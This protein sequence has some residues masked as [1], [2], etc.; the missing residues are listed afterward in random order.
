MWR[1]KN[2]EQ[3]ADTVSGKS[4]PGISIISF[5]NNASFFLGGVDGDHEVGQVVYP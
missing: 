1:A 4:Q 5:N 3:N 2:L